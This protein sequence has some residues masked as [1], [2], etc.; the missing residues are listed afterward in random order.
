MQILI[1]FF[2]QMGD[3]QNDRK[4]SAHNELFAF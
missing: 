2:G 1:Q 3:E 4:L